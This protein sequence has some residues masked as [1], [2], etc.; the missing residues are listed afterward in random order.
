MTSEL[1]FNAIGD[2]ARAR[3]AD[4]A[5]QEWMGHGFFKDMKWGTS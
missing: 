3:G 2:R 4:P 5:T 1:G